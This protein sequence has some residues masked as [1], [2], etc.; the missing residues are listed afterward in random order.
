MDRPRPM[1]VDD[2]GLFRD[3]RTLV[4]DCALGRMEMADIDLV[5]RETVAL[6]RTPQE[7]AAA[8]TGYRERLELAAE[9]LAKRSAML[10]EL[11]RL[12]ATIRRLTT[13]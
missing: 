3:W 10:E 11:K 6:G 5:L 7:L 12:D 8:I 2:P 13:A 4:A 9:L 1:G